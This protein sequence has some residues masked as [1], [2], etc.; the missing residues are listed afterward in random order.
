[1]KNFASI[2]FKSIISLATGITFALAFAIPYLNNENYTLL[3]KTYLVAIPAFA[4]TCVVYY[5]LPYISEQL[6][7]P[8]FQKMIGTR[9]LTGWMLGGIPAFFTTSFLSNFYVASHQIVFISA[10]SF[11]AFGILLHHSMGRL[12][13]FAQK[14]PLDFWIVLFIFTLPIIFQIMFFRHGLQFP[15]LFNADNFLLNENEQ[16]VF[17]LGAAAS[18]PL[19]AWIL[20]HLKEPGVYR[21]LIQ[22]KPVAFIRENLS[23]LTLSGL[24]FYLYLL[25]GSVLNFPT[26]DVDDIFFDADG[27]IWRY[28]L[29]T[30][31]WQD[32][33]WRSV[34]PLALLILKPS[35]NLLSLFLNGNLHFAAIVLTAAAGASCVFFTWMFMK[36][37]LENNTSAL[38]MAS[39][40]G[41]STSHLFFG[42]LIETYI[43]LAAA[44]LFFFILMQ[45]KN[46]TTPLLVSVGVVAMGITLTNFAQIGIALFCAKPNLKF[47]VRYGFIVVTLVISLTLVSNVFYPNASPYFFVPSS[48][49][50]ERNNVR[51]ISLSR[52]QALTRA[53]LFNNI[54]APTPMT[55][56]D[57]I[58]F[59]QFRFYRAEDYTIS[60]YS[61]PLQSA[62]EWAWLALLVVAVIFFIKDFKSHPMSLTLALIGCIAFNLLIHLKYGKELF[63][64][65]PNWTYA[66]VLLLGISWKSLLQRRVFQITLLAFLCLL[67]LNNAALFRTIIEISAPYIK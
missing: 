23:G 14:S 41:L 5:L 66:I 1:M 11:L 61:T 33:Y 12:Q 55:F 29:T 67:I 43:F 2:F 35:V 58:P 64:Y 63:L 15:V 42:A 39:L 49:I 6:K 17:A 30:D 20:R 21:A 19:L 31:H 32:F 47:L 22:N 52:V 65:S 50:A 8:E 59:T 45:R 57:Q 16:L 62:A 44:S 4:L 54:A 38:I 18:L 56:Q 60:R 46:D 34:H 9:L 7:K 24:F 51:G 27:F 48:F 53:F 13:R 10:L 36:G 37:V 26:F 25:I 40:L 3:D 28:R